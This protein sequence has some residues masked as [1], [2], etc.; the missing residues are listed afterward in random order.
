MLLGRA[1][2][3]SIGYGDGL[4]VG[5][6]GL[7]LGGRDA[8]A[9]LLCGLFLCACVSM[10]VLTFGKMKKQTAI[11]FVPFLAAGFVCELLIKMKGLG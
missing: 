9:I 7:F 10:A 1:S 11:P 2:R 3:Q 8:A 5:I 4:A 6:L